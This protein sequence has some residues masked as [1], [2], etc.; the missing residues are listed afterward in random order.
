MSSLDN[1]EELIKLIKEWMSIDNE[2]RDFNKQ[3]RTSKQN[4][5]KT[6]DDLMKMM[7]D[8]EIDQFDVKGGKLVYSKTSVK[9]PITKKSLLS[10]LSK[11]YKGD[12]SQA[13]EMNNFI[14]SNREETVKESIRR[15][16]VKS[17][18]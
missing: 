17:S 9:K 10:S 18:D 2:I 3:L 5:K 8:N 1:K 4:L 11:F 7:K 13:I 6:T 12:I 14:M 16:V 15:S